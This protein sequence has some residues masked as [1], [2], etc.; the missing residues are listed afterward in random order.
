MPENIN[1]SELREILDRLPSVSWSSRVDPVT[2]KSEWVYVSPRMAEIYGLTEAEFQVNALSVLT[3]MD[4]EEAARLHQMLVASTSTLAPL[5]WT[6]RIL[7]ASGETRWVE[8]QIAFA[9]EADGKIR[10]YGQAFDVTRRMQTDQLHRQVL[11]ALPAGVIVMTQDGKVPIQ[12][13][14][15][16]KYGGGNLREDGSDLTRRF[17]I[18][19][20]DGVTPFPDEDRPLMRALK[21]EVTHE[22]EIIIRNPHLE[23]DLWAHVKGV[24]LR[25][26][27]GKVLAGVVVFHDISVQRAL[28]KELRKRNAQLAESEEVNLGLIERLRYAVDELSTPLLEVWDDVL[29]MPIIGGVDPQRAAD[30]VR[31]LLAEV[32]RSQ[33]SFVIL[34]LTGVQ[35]IDMRFADG[36]FKLVRKVELL[37]ARCVLTGI[38]PSVSETLVEIGADF[39]RITT[40]R[41]LKH[42]LKEAIRFAR[43]EREGMHEM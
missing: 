18:F 19:K 31:R 30:I 28:D 9:R 36:L 1:A 29:L 4:P 39:G 32:A 13:H 41:N 16:Y 33:A 2:M 37:G 25:D 34:D 35:A 40:L 24:P 6:G 14:A 43:L 15:S 8:T 27:A 26:E 42:G 38:K 5:N 20:T 11:D 23:E 21:G 22:A 12:N 17:A 3:H 7:G 10:T